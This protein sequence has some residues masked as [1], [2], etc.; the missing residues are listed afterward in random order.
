MSSF[1][2]SEA[3]RSVHRLESRHTH[4]S[5]F[6]TRP[7]ILDLRDLGGSSGQLSGL[8]FW[9]R[10]WGI[11]HSRTRSYAIPLECFE[12]PVTMSDRTLTHRR[13]SR[14]IEVVPLDA[15]RRS[16]PSGEESTAGTDE[17]V[18]L[19]R[20]GQQLIR[21][22]STSSS[23][24]SKPASKSSP[25]ATSMLEVGGAALDSETAVE[26]P[27]AYTPAEDKRVARKID[28]VSRFGCSPG[29]RVTSL[30]PYLNPQVLIPLLMSAYC[31]QYVDKS[32]MSYAAVFSFRKGESGSRYRTVTKILRRL[33]I[34]T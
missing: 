2:S 22:P 26:E 34:I 14:D 1:R 9:Y 16:P 5:C 21:P 11:G 33:Q 30:S 6:V 24:S 29:S 27:I 15:R 17:T 7:G 3:S 23:M 25:L 31:L 32:A 18:R 13:T 12:R 4:V 8:Q 20:T 28:R 19:Q 10:W